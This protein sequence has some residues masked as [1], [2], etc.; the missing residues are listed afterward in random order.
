MDKS[1]FISRISRKILCIGL[2][3]F[4]LTLN[5]AA[6]SGILSSAPWKVVKAESRYDSDPYKEMSA[7]DSDPCLRNGVYHFISTGVL[8][9]K[10]DKNFCRGIAELK[11]TWKLSG[12]G[13]TAKL[14]LILKDDEGNNQETVFGIQLV[15]KEKLVLVQSYEDEIGLMSERTTF[16][17]VVQDSGATVQP[18][19]PTVHKAVFASELYE[20]IQT[21]NT[22]NCREKLKKW[23]YT[24]NQV[25]GGDQWIFE[26][27][28]EGYLNLGIDPANKKRFA[29]ITYVPLSGTKLPVKHFNEFN[30]D[31]S[32]YVISQNEAGPESGVSDASNS[33]YYKGLLFRAELRENACREFS[34]HKMTSEWHYKKLK[35]NYPGESF[36]ELEAYFDSK[37]KKPEPVSTKDKDEAFCNELKRILEL[38]NRRD[39]SEL[40]AKEEGLNYNTHIK[41]CFRYGVLRKCSSPI[42]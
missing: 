1:G 35:E 11:G 16:I 32:F 20:F 17:P 13:A 27:G 41:W 37:A 10:L 42:I 15:S 39:V 26:K 28:K 22:E 8:L 5:V 14:I 3:L 30:N 23:G 7:A 12:A 18:K 29:W 6:Q 4:L 38:A 36:P 34:V 19:Q 2:F 40:T 9:V 25:Y 33:F 24:F 21:L 31:K